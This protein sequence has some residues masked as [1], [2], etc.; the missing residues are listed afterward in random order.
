M[1]RTG[2]TSHEADFKVKVN[3]RGEVISAV[4]QKLAAAQVTL[5]LGRLRDRHGILL[6]KDML[7]WSSSFYALLR[8]RGSE[9]WFTLWRWHKLHVSAFNAAEILPFQER[10]LYVSFWKPKFVWTLLTIL[11][12]FTHSSSLQRSKFLML[13]Y[14]KT[15]SCSTIVSNILIPLFI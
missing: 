6:R 2:W 1:T 15:A 10:D 5:L 12:S 11:T 9:L 4:Q 14:D 7:F 13:T 8:M 3:D